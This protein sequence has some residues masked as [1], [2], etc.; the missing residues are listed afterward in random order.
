LLEKLIADGPA[1][2]MKPTAL[3]KRRQDRP[4]KQA[5]IMDPVTEPD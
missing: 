5:T 1:D 3:P 4:P 2:E